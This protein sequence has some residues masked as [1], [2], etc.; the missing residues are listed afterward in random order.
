MKRKLFVAAGCCAAL[1]ACAPSGPAASITNL[2][3]HAKQLRD[4]FNARADLVRLVLLVSP[5]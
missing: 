4:A 2:D 3:P 5:T 1:G